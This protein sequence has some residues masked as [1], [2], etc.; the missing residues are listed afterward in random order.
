ML[1]EITIKNFAL[2]EELHLEFEATFNVLTGETG[3]GKS[4]II[5]A[6]ELVLGGRFNS[7]MLRT[8]AENLLV[9]ATFA[10]E[11]SGSFLALFQSL[12][13]AFDPNDSLIIRREINENGKNRCRINGQ[14]VTVTT[15]IKLG[16]FLVDI[17]GQHEHQS[18]LITERQLEMLDAYCGEETK[19]LKRKFASIYTTFQEKLQE[20]TQFE[21]NRQERMRQIDFLQ[22]QVTEIE[23]AG[24]TQG[25]DEELLRE[26]ELLNAAEKLYQASGV[27]YQALLN[28][29]EGRAAVEL[30]GEAK[31]ALNEIVGFDDRLNDYHEGLEEIFCKAEDVARE[32]RNYQEEVLFNPERLDE[33]NE[34][35][36]EIN[37]L[38]R[39]YGNNITEILRHQE[40]AAQKLESLNS[41]VASFEFMEKTIAKL[42]VELTE[43]GGKLSQSRQE[44]AAK[45]EQAIIEQLRHLNMSK[46][47]FRIALTQERFNHYGMD[48][49][50]FLVAPNPGE[51]LKPLA[52]IASGG[53]M[54]RMMLALKAILAEVDSIPTLVFDEIDV[55]ISGRTAQAVA[56]KIWLIATKR[57]IICITHL[58]QIASLA[59]RHFLIEKKVGNSRTIVKMSSLSLPER[60]KELARMLGGVQVTETTKEHAR[61]MLQLAERIK[62]VK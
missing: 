8:G 43:V 45:L 34:R 23:A 60:I 17:H 29:P 61:E 44:G 22:F 10:L 30:L 37:Q 16:N 41:E 18:L 31:Q 19:K 55:G 59:Q 28:N 51:G 46:T 38:K 3:A 24:L 40:E 7:E 12:E 36:D 32:L 58:P 42:E 21:K 5:D 27:A 9:E 20:Q 1:Q 56:E 52:K 14:S 57:Q 33:I 39:K 62:K 13:I 26:R 49:V 11:E 48:R 4:I 53:E 25:E 47:T 6:L 50:E 35:L 54:S 15:L 2:I